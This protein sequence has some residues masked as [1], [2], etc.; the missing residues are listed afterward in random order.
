MQPPSQLKHGKYYTDVEF[1]TKTELWQ[2]MYEAAIAALN[3]WQ[4]NNGGQ[5]L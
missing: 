1:D 2:E 5:P 3:E 4:R